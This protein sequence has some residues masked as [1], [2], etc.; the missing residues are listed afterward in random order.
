MKRDGED[1]DPGGLS[2]E[3]LLDELQKALRRAEEAERFEEALL[4]AMTHELMTPLNAILGFTDIL[5]NGISGPVNDAQRRQLISIDRGAKRLISLVNDVLDQAKAQ[6]GQM[7]FAADDFDLGFAASK[8]VRECRPDCE[9]KGLR[10]EFEMTTGG[11]R[12]IGDCRRTEQVLRHLL[13]NAV[14]FTE[15]GEVRVKVRREGIEAAVLVIDTGIGIAPEDRDVVF[16]PFRQLDAGLERRYE[17]LGLGLSLSKRLVEGMGGRIWMDSA[18][19]RGSTFG[20]A[21]PA[22]D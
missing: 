18:P 15:Q 10:L 19:G 5:I 4:D 16:K 1:R 3:E 12:A 9:A 11:V 20:M 8:V 17:G 2:R 6:A 13:S 14:K 7:Q 21:L 22:S